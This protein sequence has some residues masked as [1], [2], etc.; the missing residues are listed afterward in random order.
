MLIGWFSSQA[1]RT[2]FAESG[3][4]Y[5]QGSAGVC[6]LEPGS[7]GTS[8]CFV[9]WSIA[10]MCGGSALPSNRCSPAVPTKPTVGGGGIATCGLSTSKSRLT[11]ADGLSCP[12]L[13]TST[14]VGR[15]GGC[16]STGGGG[17]LGLDLGIGCTVGACAAGLCGIFFGIGAMGA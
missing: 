8:S 10:K 13:V 6:H 9:G 16:C 11:T 4:S 14:S 17:S 1:K 5:H 3:V 15:I 2:L 12:G 7:W